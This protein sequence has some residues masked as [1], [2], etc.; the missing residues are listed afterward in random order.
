MLRGVVENTNVALVLVLIVVAAA[1][2]GIR[3]ACYAAALSSA[4]WF[5]FFLTVPYQRFTIED[6]SDVQT[7]I[8]L[9]A[10]GA[11]VSEIALWGRRQQARASREDGYLE[12][13]LQAAGTV[14]A[15]TSPP[16]VL[17]E[18]VERQLEDVLGLD[19][20]QFTSQAPQNVP[21]VQPD[22]TV[23]RNGHML[24]VDRDGLPTD[25]EISLPVRAGGRLRGAFV[26]VSATHIS[27]PSLR[28]RQVACALADQ[29]GAAIAT[30]PGPP[31]DG[32]VAPGSAAS[33]GLEL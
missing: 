16:A 24:N 25:T 13:I 2:T 9:L 19:R 12:G 22:G 6:P 21:V 1:S 3:A 29:V 8:L 11:A 27:R 10:V 15:G 32:S 26:L 23:L 7:F 30:Q 20:S 17:I 4:A 31:G 33:N 18:H 5:N 28:Q 14:A